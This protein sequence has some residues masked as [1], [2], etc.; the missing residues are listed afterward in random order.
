M[1]FKSKFAAIATFAAFAAT[2]TQA[3]VLFQ[4]DAA[5]GA[6]PRSAFSGILTRFT[7][8]DTV[9]LT[10]IAV[11]TDLASAGN[12]EYYIFNSLTGALLFNTGTKAFA[13][14]GQTFKTSD[15]FAFDLLV[16]NTYAIGALADVD[17][18]QDFVHPGGKTQGVVTSLG[19]N[20]NMFGTGF[21]AP[22][23]DATLRGTD[24]LVQLIGTTGNGVPEPTSL[25]L[26][27]LAIAA[28]G[29]AAR[30]KQAA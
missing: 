9:H 12:L 1:S 13:D 10:N 11:S 29:V 19:A 28:A 24:A 2:S 6:S 7:V 3:S 25:A 18:I 27:G 20:Q 30:R 16:G 15:A 5:N 21:A 26:V 17:S 14:D 8:T 4:S 22:G 23:F